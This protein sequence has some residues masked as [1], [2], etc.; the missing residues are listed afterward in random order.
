MKI[1]LVFCPSLSHSASISV[2]YACIGNTSETLPRSRIGSQMKPIVIIERMKVSGTP[3]SLT[4]LANDISR[5]NKP[6]FTIK[7]LRFVFA[8]PYQR[9]SKTGF[10]LCPRTYGPIRRFRLAQRKPSFI[11]T[12]TTIQ[13]SGKLTGDSLRLAI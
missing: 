9:R 2:R 13:V 1:R 11:S 12:N 4:P 8:L 3:N 5:D 6:R 10:D 7:E